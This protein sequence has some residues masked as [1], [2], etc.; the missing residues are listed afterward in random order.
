MPKYVVRFGVMRHL[1]IMA[2][3]D[4]SAYSRGT[5]VIARTDRGLESAVVLCEA[6]PEAV[7]DL[8][9]PG[10]GQVLRE[11]TAADVME[12]SRILN[13]QREE[14]QTCGRL[15]E[16]L[17]LDMQL[18]DVEHVFGGERV[19]IYYL[20]ENRVDFREL[21]KLLAAEF[22]TRIEMRQIGV[23]DEAKLLADYGDC[24]KPVCCNTHLSEMPPVSMK[25]AKLQKATLD[26][27]KISGRCG[28]LKCCLRYE[29]D[30]YEE[31]QKDLPPI[32]SDV[33]TQNG[34]SRVLAHEILAGQL[35]VE[36]EDR[37]R[38]LITASDVLTVLNRGE[39]L[40]VRSD[41]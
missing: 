11:M 25:M 33:L 7:K 26:P 13:Q 2:A 39:E 6:T 30:T 15:I 36:T 41:E 38:V 12:R 17:Q 4:D 34:R 23:R 31:L 37:R 27:T 19:V 3:R 32:G 10:Q 5:Q 14:F 8:K 24:G 1:A 20:S 21:V 22:Q 28:R 35:L 9:S 18:V 16:Q 29:Y 40:R